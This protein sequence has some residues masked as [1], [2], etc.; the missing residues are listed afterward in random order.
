MATTL[1]VVR[2]D[3]WPNFFTIA[4]LAETEGSR[5]ITRDFA[6]MALATSESVKVEAGEMRE[7]RGV[8]GRGERE[9][10]GKLSAGE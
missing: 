10:R 5:L 3:P 7:E 1:R 6:R 9:D 2:L 4:E 8:S